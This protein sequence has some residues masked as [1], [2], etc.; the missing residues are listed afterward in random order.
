MYVCV[1]VLC[2]Y[3]VEAAVEEGPRLAR[4]QA[5]K[6]RAD[7]TR[8]QPLRWSAVRPAHKHTHTGIGRSLRDWRIAYRNWGARGQLKRPKLEGNCTL[9]STNGTILKISNLSIFTT[10][11]VDKSL[12]FYNKSPI[13]IYTWISKQIKIKS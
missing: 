5:E 11:T 8:R 7:H 10:P 13:L 4:G 3:T 1:C 6:D 9:T 2:G 12:S